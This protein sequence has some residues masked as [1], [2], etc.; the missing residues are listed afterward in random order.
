ML[1]ILYQNVRGL[2]TKIHNLHPLQG[3]GDADVVL[4]SETWLSDDSSSTEVL[5]RY[6]KHLYRDDRKI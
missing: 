5:T 2:R 6:L 1:R 3:N 4:L